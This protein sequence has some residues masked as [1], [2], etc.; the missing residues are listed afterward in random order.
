MTK[1]A[2][3]ATIKNT[4]SL[5]EKVGQLFMPAAFI[6]DTEEEIQALERLLQDYAIGGLCF[7]HSRA[8]AATNFE[9]KKKIV[10]NEHSFDTLTRLIQRYQKAAKYPLLISIDAEWGLAMRVENTPQYPYA[11]TL[12]AIQENTALIY[13]VGKNIAHD[14]KQAGIHWNLAPVVDINN[15]PLNPVIGYR[16]FGEDKHQVV[17]KAAAF[18][19][20]ATSEGI[21]SC[22]KHFPGH[23]DTA[24]D[25]HLGL[26]V[27]DKSE[28]EL[29]DN[30]LYPFQKLINKGVD[31]VMVGHLVVPALSKG[32]SVSATLSEDIIQGVLRK[33]L[34]FKGVVISDALNMHSVSKLY[35][36]KGLLEWIAFQAG[37]DILCFAENPVEGIAHIVQKATADEIEARFSRVWALKEKSIPISTTASKTTLRNP[38]KLNTSLAQESIS[39]FK[40]KESDIKTFLQAPYEAINLGKAHREAEELISLQSQVKKHDQILVRLTP[41]QV[42][43]LDNFGLSDEQ[44]RFVQELLDTKKVL[45][46]LLGNPYVLQLF[47]SSTAMGIVIGYQDFE[48]FKIQADAHLKGIFSAKGR[49]PVTLKSK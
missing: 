14:C 35:E 2:A 43:P 32:K 45:L 28:A 4:M 44:I 7:F 23:G 36:Q 15:N 10:Y 41:P 30:E 17:H 1:I 49:V 31:A 21:L 25:S 48:T 6:N 39:L 26:P 38:K 8:S 12:G 33:T 40:G 11:I 42:K 46:Y 29:W 13:E 19:E 3:Y 24:T 16:S 20:G 27:I 18:I 37:N 5:A 22:I 34:N 9:G 47:D